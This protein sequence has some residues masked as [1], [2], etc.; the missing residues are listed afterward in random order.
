[1]IKD[2]PYIQSLREFNKSLQGL[3]GQMYSPLQYEKIKRYDKDAKG[4]IK[5]GEDGQQ[6]TASYKMVSPII[7]TV[8]YITI[9]WIWRR[10][11]EL[12][13]QRGIGVSILQI[14]H[15]GFSMIWPESENFKE[16][17]QIL[18]TEFGE[19]GMNFYKLKVGLTYKEM[20][21]KVE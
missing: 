12:C 13:N 9:S 5:I 2:H 8:E 19:W 18:N 11:L 6:L 16:I 10:F 7:Q 1:M 17:F 3:K 14:E 4:K 20:R 15:D 21:T